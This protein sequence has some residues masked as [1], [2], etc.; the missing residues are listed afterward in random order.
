MHLRPL[1]LDPPSNLH[2]Y[3]TVPEW[4]TATAPLTPGTLACLTTPNTA[5]NSIALHWMILFGEHCCLLGEYCCLICSHQPLAQTD[6]ALF[7]IGL[8]GL[9][10]AALVELSLSSPENESCTMNFKSDYLGNTLRCIGRHS[11]TVAE[12][13]GTVACRTVDCS[14]HWGHF[15][16]SSG[17]C[18]TRGGFSLALVHYTGVLYQCTIPVLAWH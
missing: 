13:S 14:V 12:H 2:H 18:G 16:C 15:K 9:N 7:S 11:G 3:L 6:T 5:L 8:H 4:A 17:I 1:Y 10:I